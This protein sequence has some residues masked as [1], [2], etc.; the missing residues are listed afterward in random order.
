MGALR[1]RA[2]FVAVLALSA[3]VPAAADEAP[4]PTLALVGGQVLDGYGGPPIRDGVVLIAGERI[5]AVGPASEIAVPEGVERISTEGM[6]VLPG[7]ADMHVHLMILGHADYRHW[8]LTYMPRFRD[9]IMPIAAKQLLTSGVTTVRDLGAR[10]EDILPVR[11]RIAK[12]EIP[13]PRVFASGPFLQRAPYEEYEKEFRW[14]I[15]GADDA[16]GKTQKLIDAGVDFI[17]L[18]DQDQLTDAEVAAI[19]ETAHRAGKKVI[20]HGHREDEIRRGLAHGVDGF[21]HTGLA[22]APGYPEDVLAGLRKRN[23]SLY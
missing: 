7:L 8:D 9:E 16:R 4:R 5:V 23:A 10:L 22:T 3:A 6:T 13:G 19:V 12:G 2:A 14:G 17:K 11:E 18:I 21:E 20:A 15:D 1:P